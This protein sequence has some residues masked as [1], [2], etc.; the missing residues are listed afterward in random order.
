MND[1][2]WR[3]N[4]Y[5]LSWF[6]KIKKAKRGTR[7]NVLLICVFNFSSQIVQVRAIE[8]ELERQEKV[9]DHRNHVGHAKN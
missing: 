5:S 2:L 1:H 4:D 8:G 6:G 7:P 9:L 3:I